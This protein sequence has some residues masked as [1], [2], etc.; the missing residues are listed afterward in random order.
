M[1]LAARVYRVIYQ[2]C[3]QSD[4]NQ[5]PGNGSFIFGIKSENFTQYQQR[6]PEI[7]KSRNGNSHLVGE[8]VAI[9]LITKYMR[10]RMTSPE[11]RKP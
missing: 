11:K 9:R 7:E 8:G 3:C 10:S 4:C 6:Q 1:Y 5:C 2:V